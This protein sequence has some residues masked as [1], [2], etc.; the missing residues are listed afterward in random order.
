VRL[1]EKA[2]ASSKSLPVVELYTD[3]ACS[4]NPGPGG[5]A[6]L[7]KHPSS[8]KS[9]QDS[10]G[11]LQTTNNRMELSAVI[12]GLSALSRPSSVDLFS[13]SKYVLDGLQSWLD[14]WIKRGWKSSTKEP[15][16]NRDLWE[17]LDVLRKQHTIRFHWV[18]G[19]N[20]H[21]EN[22]LCDRLAVEARERIART[23]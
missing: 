8:G 19:H 17:Q 7:L 9:R 5:W 22:E 1:S 14:G 11:E 6:Y 16:K 23:R 4:G 2:S 20:E 10:G 21:P 12:Q 13:D 3:G 15:V 18:K